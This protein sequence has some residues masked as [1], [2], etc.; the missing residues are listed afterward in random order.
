MLLFSLRV[1]C[2]LVVDWVVDDWVGYVVVVVVIVIQFVGVDGD[3]F[4]VGFVQQGVGVG[5]VVV[6]DYYVWF[7]VDYVVIVVLLFVFGGEVVVVGFDYVQFFQVEGFGDYF[8]EGFFF[9]VDVY[10]VG[11][12]WI[13]VQ[14][15]GYD[16]F[17][18][19]WEDCDQVVVVEVEYGV[20][21]YCGVGFWQVGDDYL[22]GGVFGEQ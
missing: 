12:V 7:Q 15:E 4:D 18:Y 8:E 17:D 10:V 22:F 21:V 19:F 9:V 2:L 13:G 14:V 5:V 11:V 20:Q 6:V 3:D 1:G 16:F